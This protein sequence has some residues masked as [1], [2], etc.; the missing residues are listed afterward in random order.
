MTDQIIK[1]ILTEYGIATSPS[2]QSFGS[3][4][5]NTTWHVREDSK[6][7]ILQWINHHVFRKPC[8]IAENIEN[9]ALHLEKNDPEYFFVSPLK[10]KNNQTMV[11]LPEHGYFRLIP[12]VKDSITYDVTQKPQ[13]AF[14]AALQFGR[15]TK[16]LKDFPAEQLKITLPDFHNLSARYEQFYH[17]C[18]HGNPQRIAEARNEIQFVQ[19]Q[20]HIVFTYKNITSSNKFKLRVTHHDTKIS[21]VLFDSNGKGICVIDLDTVMPGYFISDV[22]DMMRT[23]LSP[24]SEEETD[25]SKILIREDYFEAILNGYLKEMGDELTEDEIRHFVYAGMFLI[26]MQAIRFL[27]DHLNNDIYYGA[28]YEGHNYMRAK[29]Q[30]VLL[31]RLM[32]KEDVFNKMVSSWKVGLGIGN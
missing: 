4:L 11:H 24:V 20:Y 14:E 22:G 15:F 10:T 1:E 26:Y 5:I 27:A 12:F 8:D 21:N 30:I 6:E 31:Q 2:V 16:L 28:A 29:N 13:Q 19:Q 18:L 9:I 32:E 3:G 23:Y 7:Y 25:F 17:A